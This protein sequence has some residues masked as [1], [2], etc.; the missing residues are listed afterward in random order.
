MGLLPKA[1]YDTFRVKQR[2]VTKE[3][4]RLNCVRVGA[5][6]L[7]QLLRRPEV[8]YK[9]L[10]HQDPTISEEVAQQVEIAIKYDGYI[11]RQEQE[12]RRAGAIDDKRIPAAFDFNAVPNLRTE[13]RQKLS[14]VRPATLGQA[15]RISGVS[16]ADIGSL[17]VWLR[18][19]SQAEVPTSL[20][21]ALRQE[22]R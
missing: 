12:A 17:T 5:S 18:R 11:R 20:S 4:S 16:P 3:L 21:H 8:T 22:D 1:N 14:Q 7:A 2:E 9:S 6:T 13:A 19:A 10:P 15:S